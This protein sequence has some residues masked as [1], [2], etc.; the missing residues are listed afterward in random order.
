MRHRRSRKGGE[1]TSSSNSG[2]GMG[3]NGTGMGSSGMGS[4]GA[5]G[6]KRRNRKTN[7]RGRRGGDGAADWI[8]SNFGGTTESQFMNTFGNSG[9]GMAGNLIPTVT[10]APAV[11]PNNIPQGSLAENAAPVQEGG[12]RR[13]SRGK[14]GGYWA[15]VIETA[16]VPFGLLGL[17]NAYSKRTRK[18]RK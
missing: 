7:R 18:Q 11:L 15:Q 12:K 14:K 17:Q 4:Y 9:N 16:L 5:M 6:G 8:M 3:Y 13:K 2:T 1:D 10:G